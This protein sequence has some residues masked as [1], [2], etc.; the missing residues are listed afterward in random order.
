MNVL[1]V[2]GVGDLG[3]VGIEW[4]LGGDVEVPGEG[5]MLKTQ[6]PSFTADV[7]CGCGGQLVALG[8]G[9]LPTCPS[10]AF[11]T[12]VSLFFTLFK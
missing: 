9:P 12:L 11:M 10:L 1:L 3:V 8:A 5:G 2:K 6:A 7:V 4:A